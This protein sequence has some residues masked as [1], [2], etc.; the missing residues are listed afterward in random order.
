MRHSL[1]IFDNEAF[2]F[3]KSVS[4]D[5]FALSYFCCDVMLFA[6]SAFSE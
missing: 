6:N 1:E 5:I 2:V 3:T 4:Y